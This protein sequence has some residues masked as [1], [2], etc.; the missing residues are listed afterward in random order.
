MIPANIST[1]HHIL[2]PFVDFIYFINGKYI[3]P[4]GGFF[5]LDLIKELFAL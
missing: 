4:T 5:L 1:T 3:N 2:N